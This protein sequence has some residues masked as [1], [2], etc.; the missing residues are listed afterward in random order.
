[1]SATP[2][3]A[4]GTAAKQTDGA[5]GCGPALTRHHC[6]MDANGKARAAWRTADIMEPP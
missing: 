2:P 1:V 6:Y 3:L 4:D 5:L